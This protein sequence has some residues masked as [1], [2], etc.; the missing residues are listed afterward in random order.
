LAAL[1]LAGLG[2][3]LGG[4]LA[5]FAA[6]APAVAAD[7]P[8][9]A[10]D[11]P[12]VAAE[13]PAGSAEGRDVP[14]EEFWKQTLRP[15]LDKHC[16]ACH[17]GE[18]AEAG[19]D[20]ADVDATTQLEQQRP[21]WNQI[22]GLI[23]IGAMPPPDHDPLP[24]MEERT[25][26]ARWID[27]RI[28]TV[29]CELVT[30]PGRVTVRRLNNIEYDNTLRD[31]LGIDFS[32]S[33]QVSFPSDGVGNGFDNQGD[34]LTLSPLQLEKYMQAAALVAERVIVT[35]RESLRRQQG[36]AGTLAL[37]DKLNVRFL[38]AEGEYE[39]QTRLEF[40]DI[41]ES[42]AKVRLLVDGEE[43][44]VW[45]VVRQVKPLKRNHAFSAGWHEIG[46]EFIE[47]S[48]RETADPRRRVNAE[49][50]GI[51]G[52]KQGAPAYPEAHQRLVVAVP[53]DG[54]SVEQAAEQVFRPLLRRAF[55]REPTDLEVQRTVTL[56]KSVHAAGES[57]ETAAR[58]GLQ[59]VLV[60]PHFLFRVEHEPAEAGSGVQPLSDAALASRLSYFLW[61]SM[62]D[63]TLLEAAAAGQLHEPE[64]LA[65]QVRRML[66]D[67][68]SESLVSQF[69]VQAL[70]LGGLRDAEPDVA[71]FPAWNDRLRAAMRRETEL[72]CA[73]I[74][75]EDLSLLQLI[76]ADFTYVNP[77][78]AEFYAVDFDGQDPGKLYPRRRGG[79]FRREGNSG[80]R[81]AQYERESDWLRVALPEGRRGVIT[82]ASILTLTSNPRDTSPVKRGKWILENVLGTPPPPAPP[83]VP[84]FEETKDKHK[85]MSLRQ[86]LEL[87][88][89]NPSCASCHRVMD[90]LGL[91]FENFDPVGRWRDKD[92][93][94]PIDASGQLASGEEF[95]G[96]T[97]LVAVLE[98]KKTQVARH[99]IEKLLTYALGRGLEPY[100][101]CTVDKILVAAEADDYRL[102][103]ILVSIATS[104]PF[105][106]RRT[107]QEN[108]N[109]G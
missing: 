6:D 47:D 39:I 54:V 64:Q 10:A 71:K 7:A 89:E 86:Q 4:G 76:S 31:L 51:E 49:F 40:R 88:R 17:S 68:R 97:E 33:S 24:S 30:D 32:P 20:L 105:R 69:F 1:A 109:E 62:P 16:I 25:R 3:G 36:E 84:S 50:I 95:S 27:R 74:L 103:T 56:V 63:D 70:G 91:G 73:E 55:R 100:D 38:F 52:P 46:L 44:E 93:E 42:T 87:H 58:Y 98:T 41:P 60:S 45:D 65:S 92:G 26:V 9:V 99:F 106:L 80:A 34:V 48:E 77:R 90:P 13:L 107:S 81:D 28:N 35:D 21:R 101:T 72:V 66:R 108:S 11:E 8:A 104:D 12:V 59:S 82:H 67:P 96:A 19:V 61:A 2:G 57:F 18:D 22:R 53:G 14:Q 5:T 15:F 78:L 23:E 83:N 29:D 94:H 75:R 43:V 102:S 79:G 85:N 37:Q